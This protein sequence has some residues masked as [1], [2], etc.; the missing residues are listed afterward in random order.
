E[1]VGFSSIWVMDH[2]MQIPQVG[3]EWEDM[4]ES[5]TLLSWIAAHSTSVRLGVLVSPVT[6]RH[7]AHLAKIVATADVL[8]GGRIV[9]GLGLGWWDHEHRNYAIPLPSV[10]DRYALLEDTAQLLPVMWGPGSPAFTGQ[11]VSIPAAVCY[12]RP[13]QE[14]V[15]ILIG[16]SGR[17]TLRLAARHADA[18]N[19][20][21]AADVVRARVD[22]VRSHS[23][24]LLVTH[25]STAVTSTSSRALAADVARL[26]PGPPAHVSMERLGAGTV[27]DQIGRYAALADAGVQTAIVA[28]PDVTTPGALE[29]FGSVIRAFEVPGRAW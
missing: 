1:A 2:L 27:D 17:R 18:C 6:F 28:L 29:T 12:P 3:R 5:W 9:C 20:F 19:L 14:H 13:L 7:P 25:L 16:G 11:V 10:G 23:E 22:F 24:S 15:P 26:A 8:S 21:G 4:P